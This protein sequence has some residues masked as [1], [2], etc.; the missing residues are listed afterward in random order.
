MSF[1]TIIDAVLDLFGGAGQ[2]EDGEDAVTVFYHGLAKRGD[3]LDAAVGVTAL[4]FKVVARV[5]TNYQR[6]ALKT[7]VKGVVGDGGEVVTRPEIDE[8]IAA[9]FEAADVV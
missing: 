1:R 9:A 4:L 2:T 3:G 7:F 8:A 5:V 6:A